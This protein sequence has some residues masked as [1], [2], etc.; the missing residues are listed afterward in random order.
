M[1]DEKSAGVDL[2]TWMRKQ[3]IYDNDLYDILSSQGILNDTDF[4]D[5]TQQQW[6]VLWRKGCVERAKELKDQK[7]K[8]RLESMQYIITQNTYNI[9]TLFYHKQRK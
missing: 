4:A 7:A 2:K 6:D 9:Y 8:V 3:D 1:A 5:Y